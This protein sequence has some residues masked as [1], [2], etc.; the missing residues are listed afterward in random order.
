VRM[1]RNDTHVPVSIQL[2]AFR[3]STAH[4]RVVHAHGATKMQQTEFTDENG[5][6]VIRRTWHNA[7]GQLHR[8]TGSAV[9]NWTVLPGGAH[10]LSYQGWYLNGVP[11]RVDR[12]A[13]CRWHVAGDGTR[14]LV[15]EEWVRHGEWH[16][17][18]GPSYRKWTVGPDGVRTLGGEGWWANGK[19]HGVDGPAFFG[20]EF[21]WHGVSV[22]QQDLPW[23][24]R[25][26]GILAALAGPGAASRGHHGDGKV[27]P[28]WT[29]DARVAPTHATPPASPTYRSAVGGVVLLCV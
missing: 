9:E 8:T 1:K 7:C 20:H 21:Y 12:P 19:L 23:V 5:R 25:G 17:V 28:A 10:V 16:R 4:K 29:R 14:V 3:L 24:R 6:R 13:V 11:H 22:R 15:G 18:G 27:G 26:Q 2:S